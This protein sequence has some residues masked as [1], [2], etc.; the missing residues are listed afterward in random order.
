MNVLKI[1]PTQLHHI[2]LECAANG[3][4]VLRL[5]RRTVDQ[6]HM[7]SPSSA[8]VHNPSLTSIYQYT[9]YQYATQMWKAEPI[10]T[11]RIVGSNGCMDIHSS[12][13][14][15]HMRPHSTICSG[16]LTHTLIKNPRHISISNPESSGAV[17]SSA[18]TTFNI[19]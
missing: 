1:P 6:I 12:I 10:G 3:S 17:L 8:P 19:Y 11:M 18:G 13:K 15:K 9:G 5:F 14:F 7:A 16:P 4:Y 2:Q